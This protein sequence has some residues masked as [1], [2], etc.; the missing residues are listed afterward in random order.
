MSYRVLP[1]NAIAVIWASDVPCPKG[2][3]GLLMMMARHCDYSG[4]CGLGRYSLARAIEGK[5]GWIRRQHKVLEEAGLIRRIIKANQGGRHPDTFVL[6][7]SEVPA[8]PRQFN[9]LLDMGDELRIA[10]FERDGHKCTNC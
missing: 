9:H 10:V 3:R 6:L 8:P 4:Y 5:P 2:V 7:F 1:M